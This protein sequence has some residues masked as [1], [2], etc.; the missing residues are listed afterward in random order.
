MTAPTFRPMLASPADLN[1]LTF[2]VLVSPK[3][4]GV[5]AL[6]KDGVVLSRSLKPIPNEYVQRLFGR[7]ELEGFDGELIV[8]S[9]TAEDVFHVTSGAVR[10][11][12]GTPNVVFYVF[13]LHDTGTPY[14]IRLAMPYSTRRMMLARLIQDANTYFVELVSEFHVES[15]KGLEL[16]EE[17]CL[18][19][20]Y[21]GVMVRSPEAPYKYGRSSTKDGYLLKVKRF[22]DSE[23]RVLGVVELMHN[24][25]EATVSELGRTKRSTHQENLTPAGTMGALYVQDIHT[26]KKFHIGTGFSAEQRAWFW[27][28]RQSGPLFL[29]LIVKYK[30]FPVGVKDLPRHPAYLGIR[31]TFDL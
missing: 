15:L 3:L 22:Q 10:R 27:E 7:P 29:D 30:F 26:G 14:S 31:D 21:E 28:K 4:D 5:R 24:E 12:D 17:E 19:R 13:D 2:P 16:V 18:K 20:G 11:R 6:V 25:N 23:A 8:G 1:K 9:P